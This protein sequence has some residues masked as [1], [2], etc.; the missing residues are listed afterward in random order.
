MYRIYLL[1][2]NMKNL[3]ASSGG[4]IYVRFS[5]CIQHSFKNNNQYFNSSLYSFL[6]LLLLCVFASSIFWDQANSF[7]LV[8]GY[9][10]VSLTALPMILFTFQQT[11]KQTNKLSSGHYLEKVITW[12]VFLFSFLIWLS[13][14]F[15]SLL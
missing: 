8:A 10:V 12:I 2:L 9:I 13:L 1:T 4:F 11:N 7:T 3:S 6:L 14:T 5:P 15:T